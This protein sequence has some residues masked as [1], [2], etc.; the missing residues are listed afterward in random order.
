MRGGA[1]LAGHYAIVEW[2]CVTECGDGVVGDLATGQVFHLPV[3]G[4]AYPRIAIDSRPTSRAIVATWAIHRETDVEVMDCRRQV[5]VWNGK[6]AVPLSAPKIIAT[7][8]LDDD[9]DCDQR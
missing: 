7:V 1:N 2:G 6:A 5:F 3:G 9:K 4:D 8:R